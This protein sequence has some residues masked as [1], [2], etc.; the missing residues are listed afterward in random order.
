[1]AFID[2]AT[3]AQRRWRSR[4]QKEPSVSNTCLVMFGLV[5]PSHE[6]DDGGHFACILPPVTR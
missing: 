2:T 3:L 1:M 5:L 6:F 4:N